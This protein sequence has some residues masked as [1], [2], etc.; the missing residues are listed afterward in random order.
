MLLI[1]AIVLIIDFLT[2]FRW[3]KRSEITVF[4][5]ESTKSNFTQFVNCNVKILGELYSPSLKEVAWLETLS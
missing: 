2:A 5:W 1:V 4:V 3:A